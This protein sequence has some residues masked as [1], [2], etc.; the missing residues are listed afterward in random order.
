MAVGAAGRKQAFLRFATNPKTCRDANGTIGWGGWTRTNT[1]L[2]NSE[3]S[4]QL[5]HAPTGS[6]HSNC[7]Y[8]GIEAKSYR[9]ILPPE[10]TVIFSRVQSLQTCPM[11]ASG[12][13]KQARYACMRPPK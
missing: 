4:Y 10:R 11:L 6:S 13:A 12:L 5:D 1:V 3:V 8:L 9:A 2:I 7:T